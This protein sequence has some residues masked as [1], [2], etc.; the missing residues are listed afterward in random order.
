MRVTRAWDDKAEFQ[1]VAYYLVP[2]VATAAENE[3]TPSL[4]MATPKSVSAA[5][6][7]PQSKLKVTVLSPHES[8]GSTG[9]HGQVGL[10]VDEIPAAPTAVGES[11]SES[12]SELLQHATDR[13]LVLYYFTTFKLYF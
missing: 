8:D 5:D 2:T 1:F 9:L 3:R 13:A 12:L 7:V 4:P 6:L 11:L 10:R